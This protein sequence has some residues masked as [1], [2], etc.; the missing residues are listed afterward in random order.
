MNELSEVRNSRDVKRYLGNLCGRP[1]QEQ[2]AHSRQVIKD[3]PVRSLQSLVI[4]NADI[5]ESILLKYQE[6]AKHCPK[7]VLD[8]LKLDVGDKIIDLVERHGE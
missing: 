6:K 1:L 5:I 4:D 7:S 2:L 3:Y 8:S